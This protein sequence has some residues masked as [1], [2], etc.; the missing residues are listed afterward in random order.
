MLTVLRKIRKSLIDSSSTQKYLLYAIGEIALVV[1]GILIALQ[2]NNWNEERKRKHQEKKIL[3]EILSDLDHDHL[4]ISSDR[5]AHRQRIKIVEQLIQD[6]ISG[7]T[8]D[9]I[10]QQIFRSSID[11]QFYSK[12]SGFE[13]LK[14]VGLDIIQND[15]IRREITNLY[16]LTFQR[17]IDRGNRHNTIAPITSHLVPYVMKYTGLDPEE[18]WTM[19]FDTPVDSVI[20][21]GLRTNP[22]H[23]PHEDEQLVLALQRTLRWRLG[24]VNYHNIT[25]QQVENLQSLIHKELK[26][27]KDIQ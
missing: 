22:L 26:F 25:L 21:P 24:K 19:T 7:N 23:N 2:I 12:S 11:N 5:N 17:L 1:I 9:S 14:S 6:L 27:Q 18:E 8:H 16:D 10:A 4:E 20:I 3:I 15:T 13:N